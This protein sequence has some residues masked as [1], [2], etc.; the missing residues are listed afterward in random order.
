MEGRIEQV[1][2]GNASNHI[3]PFLWIHGE[4]EERLR[5]MV[6]RI[7]EAGIGAV[8]VE[9]RPHP[10]FLGPSWWR[11]MDIILD[12]L[13]KR[14]MKLWMLDDAHFPT[15]YA[16]GKAIG[17]P[18]CRMFLHERHLDIQGP[19]KGAS[20]LLTG[21]KRPLPDNAVLLAVVAARRIEGKDMD[22]STPI[23]IY[24]PPVEQLTDLTDLVV[25]D[26]V[27]WDIPEGRWRI[28]MIS[29]YSEDT[30]I[31]VLT[32]EGTDILINEV[33]VKHYQHYADEFG[34]TFLGFFSDEPQL[35]GCISCHATIGK[36]PKLRLPWSRDMHDKLNHCLGSETRLYW[37][38]LW[39]ETGEMTAK[40]R[41]A[42][43]DTVTSLFQK[44][45]SERIGSWC[46]SHG[47]SYI[48]HVIEDGNAHARLGPGP[49]HYYRAMWGEDF[50]GIDMVLH[51]IIPGM[52]GGSHRSAFRMESDEDF[53]YYCLAH[54]ATSIAHIDPKKKGRTVCELYGAYGW[55]EGLREMKWAADF[56]LARGINHFVPHAFSSKD[57]PDEDHP[58]H[59]YAQGHNPQYRY[60]GVLMSYINRISAI[61]SDTCH[62]TH[63]AV[64]YHA[65]AE[66]AGGNYMKSQI[67]VKIMTQNLLEADIIPGDMLDTAI[68][69][70]GMMYLNTQSYCALV[71]PYAEFLPS[72][73]IKSILKLRAKNIPVIFITD[74][75]D[76]SSS[77]PMEAGHMLAQSGCIVC[78]LDQLYHKLAII[79][80]PL[81]WTDDF[82]PDLKI[83]PCMKE[84][85]M[86]FFMHNEG[87]INDIHT[88][89]HVR[90]KRI[91]ILYDPMENRAYPANYQPNGPDR[92]DIVIKL[93]A[94]ETRILIF[95][96]E[97]SALTQ[98][99]P[100]IQHWDTS[101]LK[102]V[103]WSVFLKYADPDACFIPSD[104]HA[105]VNLNAPGMLPHF[106]GTIRYEAVVNMPA[107]V[108]ALNLGEAGETAQ[109]W[110]NN[111]DL[112][113]R[114]QPPYIFY[115]ED[116]A[117]AGEYQIRIDVTNTLGYQQ[118]DYL[119]QFQPLSASGLIGPLAIG[120]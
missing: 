52:K 72:R 47:V 95:G 17:T 105:P 67:P 116:T 53:Y 62:I 70:N 14:N 83:Y 57:F 55:Q 89:L 10:D 1:I 77:D 21:P 100:D 7:Q 110:V 80:K 68:C 29:Q 54:M 42:Y 71:V 44:N 111:R 113:V 31:N 11:D 35:G 28:F 117:F 99:P 66:W 65:E 97:V 109:V 84:K 5:E 76:A 32:E 73:I 40:I 43:M 88:V 15:G 75:P 48:G 50:G 108:L 6:R 51:G 60:L 13:K 78:S 104:I 63:A 64:L 81:I 69:K 86:Y 24:F 85:A 59:F 20:I 33:Y 58:P 27:Y 41:H 102:N 22:D 82:C 101:V 98:A 106:S 120:F 2:T 8:C 112:G 9:S 34:K 115:L 3:F 30:Y 107:G 45:F 94:W 61:L 37:P 118:R 103:K 96:E 91:P 26:A 18:H 39:Y 49:G 12:E 56:M 87:I 4:N 19:K 46:R 38:G 23:D 16:N 92:M 36:Y 119:S 74:F 90:D 114:L 93:H 25:D 79:Q